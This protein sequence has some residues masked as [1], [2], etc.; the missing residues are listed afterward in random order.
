MMRIPISKVVLGE[1]EK[2]A[3]MRVLD[4]GTLVQGAEVAAFER[5]FADAHH[6]PHAV[7]VNNGTSALIAALLAHDIGRDD[8]V[9]VPAFSFFA[10]A[11]SVLAV[12]ATP[13]FAD[14]EPD[15]FCLSPAS[16]ESAITPRTKAIMPV[17]L[18]GQMADMPAFADLCARH[19]LALVEDA[20]QA[21]GALLDG[22]FPGTWGAATFSLYA[23]KN[24]TAGEGGMILTR[25]ADY[26]GRLRVIRNQG[27]AR[28]YLHERLGYNLRM[29]EVAA[30]IG[31]VQLAGLAAGNA[32]RRDNAAYFSRHL[33][34]VTTPVER[35]GSI[36]C[37]HQY[38]IVLPPALDRDGF[39]RALH[40]AGIDARVYYP[41]PLH[42]QPVFGSVQPSLP[43]IE[44]AA[45]HVLS[46]PVHPHL[47]ADERAYIVETVNR[48]AGA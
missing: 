33:R 31:R 6:A 39:V 37:W 41:I 3:V 10:T 40:D 28:Q 1:A 42:R 32:A 30:A 19:G 22:Q 20:A 35:P 46:L 29:T 12:G 26:A 2:Q 9:I 5:E 14:I 27:M 13:V 4:D 44:Y 47:T 11:S 48:L 16:A 23:S 43:H 21:H 24:I 38:T 36:S 34:G 8:E 25:D 15:T 7:A 18:F 45:A 17:H